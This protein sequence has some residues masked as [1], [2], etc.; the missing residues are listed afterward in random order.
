M[1]VDEP[2]NKSTNQPIYDCLVLGAGAAG[3]TASIYLSRYKLSHVILG[4][5]TG[6]QFVDATVVENYPGFISISGPDLVQAFHEHVES[7]GV[8]IQ[9]ERIGEI[10][11]EGETFLAKN[12]VGE[13]YRAKSLL[14]ALGA[15]HKLLNVPGED[16]FLSKGVSYCATCDAPLFKGKEVAVIGGG[17]SAVT[18]AIHVA[19][20]AKKVYIVHRRGEY[21]AAPHE[22]EKMR[23]L[24]NVVEV[25][26]N[27]V[28]E[29]QGKDFVEKIILSSPINQSSNQPINELP[30]QGV[31]VEIGLIPA[32]SLANAL[33]VE[34][35][36]DGYL[37]I[38]P[39]METNVPGVFAAG[40]LALIP[41]AIPFRQIVNSAGEG[42]VAAA[43]VYQFL[44]KQPPVPDW[45]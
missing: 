3:M 26:N 23:S 39:A 28:K 6:G 30:V 2:M 41:G 15:R 20:F 12:S 37:K 35:T 17:N 11:R 8:K 24:K 34:L 32:S 14:L 29:I 27:T 44:R 42:A 40:D 7:Y 31:F 13:T 1:A 4:E 25:L 5:I 38:N 33:G 22:V 16:K 19:A 9:Q 10:K 21:R 18:A 36:E 43:A 45:G